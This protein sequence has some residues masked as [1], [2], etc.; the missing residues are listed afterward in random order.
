MP[1]QV[2]GDVLGMT[3]VEIEIL[4]GKGRIVVPPN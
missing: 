4:P 3:P 1:V 2:D